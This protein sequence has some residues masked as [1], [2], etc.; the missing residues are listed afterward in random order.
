MST[1]ID[2]HSIPDSIRREMSR[3]F[4]QN[5]DFRAARD[6]KSNQSIWV[7]NSSIPP[8]WSLGSCNVLTGIGDN[9]WDITLPD[10]VCVDIVPHLWFC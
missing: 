10:G 4:I 8:S 9:D 2:K 6:M 5:A 3:Q 7:E 1:T